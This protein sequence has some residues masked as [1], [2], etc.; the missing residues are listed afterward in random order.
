MRHVDQERLLR[1]ADGEL[2]DRQA[3]RVREHLQACWQCR[4]ELEE[5]QS[6][7]G[8]CVRYRRDVLAGLLPPPPQPW[9]DIYSGFAQLDAARGRSWLVVRLAQALQFPFRNARRWVPATVALTLV[10]ALIY[11]L[12]ETPSV[13]AAELLRKAVAAAQA[14]PAPARRI[15]IRTRQQQV[16]RTAGFGQDAALR[17][18][19]ETARYDWRDPLSAHAFQGWRETLPARRDEVISTPD[20]Y[21]IRTTS[22]TGEL[23]EASLKLRKPDLRPTEGRFEF[24]NHEWVEITELPPELPAVANL[25]PPPAL[26]PKVPVA[27]PEPP[28]SAPAVGVAEE[29]RVVAA[30]HQLGA[31]LGDPVEISRR[32]GRILVSGVGLAPE[33]RQQIQGAL[34]GMPGVVMQ[35]SDGGASTAEPG[36]SAVPETQPGP[37]IASLQAHLEKQA[38]GRPQFERLSAQLLDTNEA[39]MSRAY[40]LRRLAQRFPQHAEAGMTAAERRVLYG[41]GAEHA[42]HLDRAAAELQRVLE[43]LLGFQSTTPAPPGSPDW[44]ASV[45]ALFPASRRVDTLLAAMLGAAAESPVAAD[46]PGE[47]LSALARLRAEAQACRHLTARE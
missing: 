25:T 34:A 14:N 37:Q 43:P 47:L 10:C 13:E 4:T 40:A 22:D 7:V 45:E 44:Q 15:Q 33:R 11:Q 8:E 35:F 17:Q 31:D 46:L 24:R 39:M 41:L 23:R 1:Y 12:R 38:G 42:R 32:D 19:F 6:T 29:L 28:P 18:L 16:T 9:P 20:A 36:P 3:R 27:P 2:P 30:L 26:A 5:L 21:R